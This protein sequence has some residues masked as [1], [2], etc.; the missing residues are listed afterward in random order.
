MP[1]PS[2][3]PSPSPTGAQSHARRPA[4]AARASAAVSGTCTAPPRA[5]LSTCGAGAVNLCLPPARGPAGAGAGRAL[6][7]GPLPRPPLAPPGARRAPRRRPQRARARSSA[8]S[9]AAAASQRGHR[10]FDQPGQIQSGAA[11]ATAAAAGAR[12]RR[13]RG[14]AGCCQL[15][16]LHLDELFGRNPQPRGVRGEERARPLPHACDPRRARGPGAERTRTRLHAT[17]THTCC[18]VIPSRGSKAACFRAV[19]LS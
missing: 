17:N 13:A 12:Q 10:W 3:P 15:L 6:S 5:A 18:V 16:R 11:Q 4:V 19:G 7:P 8:P 2:P 1:S 14:W 9:A